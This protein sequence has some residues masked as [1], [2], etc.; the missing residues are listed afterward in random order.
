[1]REIKSS[2]PL[3]VAIHFNVFYSIAY[4][5]VVGRLIVE[6]RRR[7]RFE[8]ELQRTVLLPIFVIWLIVEFPRLRLGR[9]GNSA[10]SIPRLS[11]FILLTIFPQLPALIYLT[12]H[13]EVRFPLDGP[14]GRIMLIFLSCEVVLGAAALRS[15]VRHQTDEFYRNF[16]W[17]REK[18]R[19]EKERREAEVLYWSRD[20]LR[21]GGGGGGGD[22]R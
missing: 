22:S 18:V 5:I 15:F 21:G 10:E 3:A 13:Q 20:L 11:S 1:M 4:A 16:R 2:L 17:E 12:Y 6:K 7:F 14:A 19:E 9:A 8:D